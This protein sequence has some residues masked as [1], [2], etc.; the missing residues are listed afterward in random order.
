MSSFFS[1]IITDR[2]LTNNGEFQ[3]SNNLLILSRIK[4]ASIILFFLNFYFFYIDFFRLEGIPAT[5][6]RYILTLIHLLSFTISIVFLFIYRK[7]K[8]NLKWSTSIINTFVFC[9][10]FGGAAVSINSQLLNGNISTY[11][12]VLI[13]VAVVFP[14]QP[15]H[16]FIIIFI[17]HIGFLLGLSSMYEGNRF[18]LI[19]KQINTTGTA[20]FAFILNLVFYTYRKKEFVSNIKIRQ[21]E[22]NLRNLFEV[23]PFPQTLS[24]LETGEIFY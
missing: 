4:I 22:E 23:N 15:K 20:T 6:Y 7:I 16:F 12:I 5:Q 9:Y 8:T 21:S 10:I 17:I 14:I 1:H 2:Q 24:C 19:S 13:C 3:R 11:L 18:D